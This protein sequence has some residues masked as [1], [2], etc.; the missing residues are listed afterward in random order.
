MTG[1]TELNANSDS[2]EDVKRGSW[3]T[4]QRRRRSL[5]KEGATS[6]CP[7]TPCPPASQLQGFAHDVSSALKALLPQTLLFCQVTASLKDLASMAPAL[8]HS[9]QMTLGFTHH[10]CQ[11]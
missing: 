1:E 6:M 2:R 4:E 5:G 8:S 10:I 9:D 7:H 3:E 11:R